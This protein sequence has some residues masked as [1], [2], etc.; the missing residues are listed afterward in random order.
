MSGVDL[1]GL[2]SRNRIKKR[3]G[4][5]VEKICKE[6]SECGILG[7]RSEVSEAGEGTIVRIIGDGFVIVN[8]FVVVDSVT[9]GAPPAAIRMERFNKLSMRTE[10]PVEFFAVVGD[11]EFLIGRGYDIS[12]V[13]SAARDC[14]NETIAKTDLKLSAFK[15]LAGEIFP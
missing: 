13:V 5:E 8:R 14:L 7:F 3:G 9:V 2:A 1:I 4:I 12:Y 11:E 15:K 10:S 6:I